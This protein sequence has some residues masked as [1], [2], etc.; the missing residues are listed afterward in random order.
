MEK[1]KTVWRVDGR[2]YTSWESCMS[3]VLCLSKKQVEEQQV[4]VLVEKANGVTYKYSISRVYKDE[5]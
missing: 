5:F 3:A 4:E 2:E 1:K